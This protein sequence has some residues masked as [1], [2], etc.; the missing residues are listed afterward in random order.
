MLQLFCLSACDSRPQSARRSFLAH[1]PMPQR[2]TQLEVLKRS[3]TPME[4]KYAARIA[5]VIENTH[6]L[7]VTLL[8][9]NAGGWGGRI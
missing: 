9:C 2:R 6:F 8:I 5:P 3:G 7:L 4:Q 1:V